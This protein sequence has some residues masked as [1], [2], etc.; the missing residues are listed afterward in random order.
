ML[1]INSLISL[2]L[3]VCFVLFITHNFKTLFLFL[4]IQFTADIRIANISADFGRGVLIPYQWVYI[5]WCDEC[6]EQ[7]L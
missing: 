6:F 3:S 2:R 4:L 1:L 5:D 7:K